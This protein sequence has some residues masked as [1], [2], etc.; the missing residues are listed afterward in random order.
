MP[1]DENSVSRLLRLESLPIYC[2]VESVSSRNPSVRL[3]K[4]AHMNLSRGDSHQHI[5]ITGSA[6]TRE[7]TLGPGFERLDKGRG[8]MSRHIVEGLEFSSLDPP[9][10]E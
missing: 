9:D 2:S 6:C 8:R 4:T 3:T 5:A 10:K 7:L 1:G